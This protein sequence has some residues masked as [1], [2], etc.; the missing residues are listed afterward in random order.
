M[1]IQKK[2]KSQQL[3]N[4]QQWKPLAPSYLL[5]ALQAELVNLNS[6]YT[7]YKPLILTTEER[8]F[9]QWHVTF[10]QMHQ[11]KPL[12]LLRG[13]SPLAHWDSHNQRCKR[14]QEKSQPAHQNTNPP[15]RNIG[16]CHLNI[17]HHQMCHTSQQITHQHNDASSLCF[18]TS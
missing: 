11:E 13:C 4:S 1:F 16:T 14:Y 17:K 3:L 5:A 8:T 15:T 6:I 18:S 2:S 12:T 9:F 10:R 7:L